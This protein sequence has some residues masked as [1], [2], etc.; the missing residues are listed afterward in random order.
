M[1]RWTS[2]LWALF[3]TRPCSDERPMPAAAWRYGGHTVLYFHVL[4]LQ[5]PSVWRIR[6]R[7]IHLFL[8][9]PGSRSIIQR[10]RSGS[11]YRQ[12]KIVSGFQHMNI[13]LKSSTSLPDFLRSENDG[14]QPCYH[15]IQEYHT[16]ELC[17]IVFKAYW[18]FVRRI[19]KNLYIFLLLFLAKA[20][21]G[22][23]NFCN[24]R[25]SKVLFLTFLFIHLSFVLNLFFLSIHLK[26]ETLVCR[27]WLR[28]LRRSGR[29]ASPPTPVSGA[30]RRIAAIFSPAAFNEIPRPGIG[31]AILKKVFSWQQCCGSGSGI[32]CLFDPWIRDPE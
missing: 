5:I 18:Y 1:G 13:S 29:C 10:Y 16:I 19:F 3:C 4:R 21:K 14:Y 25:F 8:G 20:A 24:C 26:T 11:F 2:G 31:S 28:E 15:T 6:I 12:A 32:R 22:F 7:R 23:T 17:Y 9:P 27:S 30:S